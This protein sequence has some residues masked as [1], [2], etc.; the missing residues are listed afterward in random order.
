MKTM[1]ISLPSSRNQ[2]PRPQVRRPPLTP[3]TISPPSLTTRNS[4]SPV[5]RLRPNVGQRSTSASIL[6]SKVAT[7]PSSPQ[8]QPPSPLATPKLSPRITNYEYESPRTAKFPQESKK[9]SASID[10]SSGRLSP[11]ALE[12]YLSAIEERRRESKLPEIIC[13]RYLCSLHT[14]GYIS[15][16]DFDQLGGDK[17]GCTER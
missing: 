5:E 11:G 4:T 3:S 10:S 14:D 1:H 9:A 6:L 13:S 7:A 15:F 17:S 12:K 16:P 2:S 8:Y